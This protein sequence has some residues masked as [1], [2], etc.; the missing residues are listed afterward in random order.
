MLFHQIEAILGGADVEAVAAGSDLLPDPEVLQT[1]I[2]S[3]QAEVAN[4]LDNISEEERKMEQYR[5]STCMEEKIRLANSGSFK[6]LN[7]ILY[8]DCTIRVYCL[9]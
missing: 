5:V 2:E 4:L 9:Y 6:H 3:S 8:L 1:V 7:W